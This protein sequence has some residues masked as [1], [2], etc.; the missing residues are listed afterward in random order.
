[1]PRLRVGRDALVRALD[2]GGVGVGRCA[3]RLRRGGV[4][5]GVGD[6]LLRA[7]PVRERRHQVALAAARQTLLAHVLERLELVR[8]VD[9]VERRGR[10]QRHL[11][12]QRA[13]GEHVGKELGKDARHK[14]VGGLVRQDGDELFAERQM[15]LQHHLLGSVAPASLACVHGPRP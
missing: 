12:R 5:L 15:Q 3:E 8:T 4:K 7:E 13:G 6:R 14:R 10:V 2:R 9:P 11:L 1:V